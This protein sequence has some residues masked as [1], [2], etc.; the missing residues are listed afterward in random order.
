MAVS[1]SS[2]MLKILKGFLLGK[3]SDD[4]SPS[5]AEK[6]QKAS[7]ALNNADIK[8]QYTPAYMSI[9]PGLDSEKKQ[10]FEATVYYLTKIA[11]K[12][13][14]Y[15]DDILNHLYEKTLKKGINPDFREYIKL[16]IK[17]ISSENN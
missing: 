17:K 1:V 2:S 5:E 14:R 13:E 12:K 6:I 11:I 10:V 15:R 4:I 8:K 7:Y 16:N 9:L 3:K